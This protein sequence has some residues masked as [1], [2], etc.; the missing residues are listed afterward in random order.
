MATAE[1]I[2]IKAT[3]IIPLKLDAWLW[4]L[5]IHIALVRSAEAVATAKLA[6]QVFSSALERKLVDKMAAAAALTEIAVHLLR[7]AARDVGG[8]DLSEAGRRFYLEATIEIALQ[9]SELDST[10][11][12]AAATLVLATA[13]VRTYTAPINT[14]AFPNR[15]S[16]C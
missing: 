6:T 16:C 5:W 12:E 13:Q 11:P 7:A 3:T 1:T 2:L 8:G 14:V 4:R 9:A 10:N 15:S